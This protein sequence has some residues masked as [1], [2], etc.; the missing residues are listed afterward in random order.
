MTT[1][2]AT[3]W[4]ELPKPLCGGRWRAAPCYRLDGGPGAM[5]GALTRR[6][7]HNVAAGAP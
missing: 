2:T 3:R 4:R 5:A 1:T 7:A 6:N